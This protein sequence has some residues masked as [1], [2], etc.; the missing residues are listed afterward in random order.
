MIKNKN[1]QSNYIIL[2]ILILIFFSSIKLKANDAFYAKDHIIHD[3]KLNILW[4]RC[5][6]GQVWNSKTKTCDGKAIK[7]KMKHKKKGIF[8]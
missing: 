1:K 3:L 2:T 4:L 7:L 8:L 6:V 5:S